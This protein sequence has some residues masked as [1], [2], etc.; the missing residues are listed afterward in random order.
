MKYA[1]IAFETDAAEGVKI[2]RD[3]RKMTH[4]E[5]RQCGHEPTPVL[6]ALRAKC[7]DCCAGSASEVRKCVSVSCALWPFRINKNVWREKREMSEEQREA[8]RVRLQNAR[9]ANPSSNHSEETDEDE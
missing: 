8:A 2:G 3:P 1:D 5:L 6:A 7:I 9:L 4:D